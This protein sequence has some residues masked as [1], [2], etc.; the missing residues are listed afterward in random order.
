MFDHESYSSHEA[1]VFREDRRIGLRAVIAIHDTTLGP[2]AGGC[3]MWPYASAEAAARDALRLSEAMT[4]KNALAGLPLGGGKSVILGDAR[5]ATPAHFEAFGRFI[6]DLGGRYWTAEDV[7]VGLEAV[8]HIAAT[9]RY[10]FGRKGGDPAPFTAWGGLVGIEAA[11]AEHRGSDSL[12]GVRVAVQG[13]GNVGRN[14]CRLLAERGA[15]LVV[16]DVVPGA[17]ERVVDAAGA[18]AVDPDAIY[19]AEVDVFAPCAL[20]AVLND[21]TVPRLRAE[22]VCGLANNQLADVADA[23][24]LLERGILYAPDYVVNAGGMLAASA[25]IFG[26]DRDDDAVRERMLGIR[27]RLEAIFERA[28]AEGA[29]PA[30]V[31]DQMARERVG[32]D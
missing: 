15:E 29:S 9:T 30:R 14:L 11:L 13:L 22:I 12:D 8:D 4:W 1:L 27:T 32:R 17:V 23:D 26:E 20:G 24:A 19:D 31:A 21:A 2:A 7:G 16:T 18:T 28:N 3:R 25:E 5:K 10:V 6:E